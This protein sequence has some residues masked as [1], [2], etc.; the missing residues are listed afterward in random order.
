MRFRA[1]FRLGFHDPLSIGET[2]NHVFSVACAKR[3]VNHNGPI[4]DEQS[5]R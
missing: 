2:V 5:R 1:T 3:L 4:T